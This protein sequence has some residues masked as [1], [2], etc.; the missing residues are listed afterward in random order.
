MG[1]Q[2]DQVAVAGL[3]AGGVGF[4]RPQGRQGIKHLQQFI[5]LAGG[6]VVT[7]QGRPEQAGDPLGKAIVGQPPV[8]L[9]RMLQVHQ[10]DQGGA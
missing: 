3:H 10:R 2:L 5:E 9:A 8:V 1:S 6:A 4:G 7:A